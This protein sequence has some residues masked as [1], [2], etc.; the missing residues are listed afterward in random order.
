MESP[1]M[2]Y[3]YTLSQMASPKMNIYT[4]IRSDKKQNLFYIYE[5]LYNVKDSEKNNYYNYTKSNSFQN[6][7]CLGKVYV[8]SFKD[9]HAKEKFFFT[10]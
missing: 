8:K 4:Y 3:L 6:I 7:S 9:I 10:T 5:V 1:L 2:M